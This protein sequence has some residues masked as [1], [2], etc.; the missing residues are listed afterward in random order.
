MRSNNIRD[1]F[2]DYYSNNRLPAP[3]DFDLNQYKEKSD[4]E[5]EVLIKGD[6]E[7]KYLQKTN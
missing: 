7:K 6:Y 4:V 2:L 1:K 5:F 3:Y